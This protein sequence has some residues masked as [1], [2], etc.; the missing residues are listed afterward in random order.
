MR[1]PGT[2]GLERCCESKVVS[3][4]RTQHMPS[5]RAQTRSAQSGEEC[6]NQK[7]SVPS[8]KQNDCGL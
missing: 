5:A 6:T 7:A 1:D 8:Q 2:R 3:S 4:L